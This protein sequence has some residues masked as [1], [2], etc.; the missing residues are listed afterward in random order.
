M[1]RRYFEKVL[2]EGG[3]SEVSEVCRVNLVGSG[4]DTR[5]APLSA[6]S[7]CVSGRFKSH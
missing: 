4:I 3:N 6:L 2:N 1:W 7:S 5:P